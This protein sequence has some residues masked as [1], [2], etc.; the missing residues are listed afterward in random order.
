MLGHLGRG[1]TTILG[2]VA[3]VLGMVLRTVW[4]FVYTPFHY[5][6]KGLVLTSDYVR[7][8][9]AALLR[10]L[11]G[12][13]MTSLRLARTAASTTVR[14]VQHGTLIVGGAVKLAIGLALHDV[15][16]GLGLLVA[17]VSAVA[18]PLGLLVSSA[19]AGL[20][21]GVEI[22]GLGLAAALSPIWLGITGIVGSLRLTVTALMGLLQRVSSLA[23]LAVGRLLSVAGVGIRSLAY[24][25]GLLLRGVSRPVFLASRH[26]RMGASTIALLLGWLIR[27]T[28]LIG[29]A[30][31]QGLSRAPVFVARTMWTGAGAVPDVG[32]AAVGLATDRKGVIA[33]SDHNLTRQRVLSLI[34][35]LWVLGIVGSL[36]GW[37]LWPTPPEPTVEVEHWATGHLMREGEDLRLLPVMAEQFNDAGHRNQA[38]TRIVVKIHNV[39]SQLI[40]EYLVARVKSG[41]RIDL[42]GLTDGYVKPG[43][44]DPTVVT[45]SSAHWLVTVNHQVERDV[46]DLGAARSIVRPVIGI[47]TYE[48]MARCL[49]WPEKELGYADILALR[50]DPQGWTKYPCASPLWGPKPLVAFTDPTT[51][52][53]GRSLLLGLY[54]IAA[55]KAPEELTI[56]DVNDPA[57]AGYVRQFQGLVDHY[58]IGT[59][60]LNTKIHQGHRYGHFFIMPEDNLIHLYEGTERAFI[61]GIKVQA[62]RIAPGSMVMIY[63]KEGSMP[64]S[65]CACIV[66]ADWV[67]PEQVEA[68]QQWIDFL[69]EDA[70]Q[71][72]FMAA[73]FRPGGDIPLTDPSSKINAR[74]GLDPAKPTATLNP[75][76]IDPAAA[77]EIDE[78]WQLVKRPGIVTFVVD[79]SGSMMGSKIDQARDGLVRALH[80]MAK[81]NQVG[82]VGFGE[83]IHT[84]VP[85]A[86]LAKNGFRIADAAHEMRARGETALYDAI[87]AGVEMSDAAEGPTEA[88]R[89]V[90]VLTDGRANRGQVKL[91]DLI[92]ISSR[93]ERPV[94]PFTG[95]DDESWAEAAGGGR[96]EKADLIGDELAVATRHD[97]QIFFIGIGDDA[98]L[99]VGRI[100]AEAT[101]AEFQGVAEKDLAAVLEEF[102]KY[103]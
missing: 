87:K 59:T 100:L 85:V 3:G 27:S 10:H 72:G 43:Y 89:A 95:F 65:N 78:N 102:S 71:R 74:Y 61:N 32:K 88:I 86:P 101:G 90:V 80:N 1:T 49:G 94:G 62:P 77:A 82:L 45:P 42:T 75:S 9:A 93:D 50:A 21:G 14:P 15:A 39:P 36:I 23:S 58:L 26:L 4:V 81:D 35:T 30:T 12:A 48:E 96:I 22:V 20:I 29:L 84:R 91:H 37:T 5:A 17:G 24:A 8:K 31:F 92:R 6:L 79:T 54:S 70:Q 40:G 2:Y 16:A 13:L 98:D 11:N 56:D 44:S 33:M 83:S 60:V 73:G 64:R 52:S 53:T 55:D 103:F 46:V 25:A 76:L 69:L 97:I 19:M 18:Q 7:T 38:G 99:D 41:R 68:A 34:G 28:W 63:P 51:S 47:V 66:Q 57:V 67:T